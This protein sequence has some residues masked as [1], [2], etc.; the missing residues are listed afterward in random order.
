MSLK[1]KRKQRTAIPPLDDGTYAARC[2]GYAD[3]GDQYNEKYKNYNQR[4]ILVFEIIGKTLEID[5][6]E[7]PRWMTKEM[8]QSLHEKSDMYEYITALHGK[9]TDDADDFDVSFLLGKPAFLQISV[10]ESKNSPGTMYNSIDSIVKIPDG[11][12]VAEQKSEI[13]QLDFEDWNDETFTKLPEWIQNKIR[14]SPTFQ[15]KFDI[16]DKVEFEDNT[17]ETE[18]ELPDTADF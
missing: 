8:T 3:L 10:K 18:P 7:K 17:A 2:I 1:I 4:L 15:R 5:G 9:I 6:E 14:N 13:F 12:P 16:P 11:I